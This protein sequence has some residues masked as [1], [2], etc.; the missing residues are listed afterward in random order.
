MVLV[1]FTR[2]PDST[3]T[4]SSFVA[5]Q[6]PFA[7]N[8]NVKNIDPRIGLAF[9][10]FADH[11]TSIRA[12]FGMFHEAVTARTFATSFTPNNPIFQV[13]LPTLYGLYPNLPTSLIPS[14][15]SATQG[16]TWFAS[17]QNNV[18]T[19]PY[20]MQ[21]NLTIQRQL[22]KGMLFNIGYNGSAGVHEFSEIQGNLPTYLSDDPNAT[23]DLATGDYTLPGG[24][25]PTGTGAPGTVN[26]P[27]VGTHLDPGFAGVGTMAPISHSS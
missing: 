9:D 17:I 10:P 13:T 24:G 3:T 20:V 23:A 16:I 27:F 14:A 18:N 7:S 25:Q 19:S 22:P 2:E 26:N 6:H 12:G 8:P 21:Y 11:K 4:E 5:A 15:E 1:K